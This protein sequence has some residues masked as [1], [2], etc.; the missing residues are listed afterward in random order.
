V[1]NDLLRCGRQP[2]GDEQWFAFAALMCLLIEEYQHDRP[3]AIQTFDS[4]GGHGRHYYGLLWRRQLPICGEP[5]VSGQRQGSNRGRDTLGDATPARCTAAL[6]GQDSTPVP[7]PYHEV[8]N[9]P[10]REQILTHLIF[11]LTAHLPSNGFASHS[12]G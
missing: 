8:F 3:I 4:D 6:G 5:G 11:W 2:A 9:E 7:G 12:A 1:A 10:E